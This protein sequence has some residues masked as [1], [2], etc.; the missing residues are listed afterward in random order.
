M[1]QHHAVSRHQVDE[2]DPRAGARSGEKQVISRSSLRVAMCT[3]AAV[4]VLASAVS[5]RQ[6][7]GTITLQSKGG[8]V[9]VT[10]RHA[11]LVKGPDPVTGK[12]IRRIVL[13]SADISGALK[14]CTNMTCSDGGIGEGMTIDLD[15][16]PRINYWAVGNDQRI[17]HSATAAPDSLKLTSDTPQRVAG[18]WNFDASAAGGPIVKVEFDAALVKELKTAR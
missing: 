6:G 18:Q 3:M 12:P 14:A 16:G 9:I 11:Y 10:I 7:K 2:V 17:Q 15:A 8:A 13:S 4:A 1:R 5:A